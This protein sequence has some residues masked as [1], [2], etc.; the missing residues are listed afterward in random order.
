MGT[1]WARERSL[2]GRLSNLQALNRGRSTR[3]P[4]HF[5]REPLE[6]REIA[7]S[8]HSRTPPAS[9]QPKNLVRTDEPKLCAQFCTVRPYSYIPDGTLYYLAFR[10]IPYRIRQTLHLMMCPA[11]RGKLFASAPSSHSLPASLF[12]AGR[13]TNSPQPALFGP[14]PTVDH[15][16]PPP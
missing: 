10:Y 13:S 9:P 12:V 4:R 15:P 5:V 8:I 14:A 2:A 7:T 3:V 6:R 1:R 16:P 11:F